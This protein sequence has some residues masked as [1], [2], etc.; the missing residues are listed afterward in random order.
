MLRAMN[1]AEKARAL[2][3]LGRRLKELRL[4]ERLTQEGVAELSGVTAGFLSEI[5][6]GRRDPRLSTLVN[7]AEHGLQT[8]LE[9]LVQG[10]E[11]AVGLDRR[12]PHEAAPLPTPIARLA[13]DIAELPAAERRQVAGVVRAMVSAFRR[14][15]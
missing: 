15:P 9:N 7:I 12:E 4:A 8:S 3:L 2:K 1:E 14:G 6:R 11:V 13:R 10:I 5:E